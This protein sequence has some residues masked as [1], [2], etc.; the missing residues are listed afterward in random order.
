M[1]FGE[2]CESF[3]TFYSLI[4][5][6]MIYLYIALGSYTRKNTENTK[7]DNKHQLLRMISSFR[8]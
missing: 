6:H 8:R 4:I 1:K 5:F 7:H 2:I 3:E